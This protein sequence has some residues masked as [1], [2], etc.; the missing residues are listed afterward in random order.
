MFKHILLIASLFI[1]FSIYAQN[2]AVSYQINNLLQ[3]APTYYGERGSKKELHLV[4]K[5]NP[6]NIKAFLGLHA[7]I[8]KYQYDDIM[9]IRI[10]QNTLGD[11]VSLKGLIKAEIHNTPM[12]VMDAT[13]IQL[14]S[15]DTVHA[16]GGSL[17]QAYTGNGV[18]VGI[19]DSG[20]DPTHPDFKNDDG[21]TR[22]LAFWDQNDFSGNLAPYGYGKEYTGVDIDAGLMV[23]Y[24]DTTYNGHGTAVTG[25]AAGGGKVRAD[26]KGMAPEA[27]IVVVGNRPSDLDYTNRMPY[28]LKLVDGI[29]YIF[30]VAE[31]A[32]KPAVI[33]ISLGGIEGSHDAQDLPTQLIERMLDAKNGRALVVSA[34][35]AGSV[36]HHV[37]YKMNRD[38]AFTWYRSMHANTGVCSRDSGAYMSF[39]GDEKDIDNLLINISAENLPCCNGAA[40]ET[41]YRVVKQTVGQ[42]VTY[43]LNNGSTQIGVVTTFLEKIGTTYGY[44]VEIKS[45]EMNRFWR[46]SFT[47]TGKVDGW[48]GPLNRRSCNSDFIYNSLALGGSAS[49][50]RKLGRYVKP[51]LQQNIG[52]AYA[53]SQKVITVGAYSANT[54]MYDI[55]SIR[56]NFPVVQKDRIAFSSIGPTR[57]GVTKPDLTGPGSRVITAQASQELSSMAIS[58]RSSLYLGGKHSVIDGTSFSSPAVAGIVALYLEKN[59]D[60]GYAEIKRALL[61]TTDQ[62]VQ[63]GAEMPNNE[64][65]YGRV[66]AYQMLLYQD[67]VGINELKKLDALVYPNPSSGKFKI[68]LSRLDFDQD[69]ELTIVDLKGQTILESAFKSHEFEFS[70]DLTG[71]YILQL[72]DKEENAYFYKLIVQ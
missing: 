49:E 11:L 9:A 60:A 10:P 40:D 26:V 25:M 55:D 31:A 66:N 37:Q 35:N 53:C 69:Y 32:G 56:R 45:Q 8:L 51:D 46:I 50:T 39:Y 27:D 19:I 22:I 33:N 48:S 29:N 42:K 52:N 58:S 61:N 47:G 20:I 67:P 7:G 18:V 30:K 17:Q 4:V 63:T 21:T 6:K 59:P 12:E 23:N 54:H 62:D 1:T 14:T 71:V 64:N 38:T 70:I 28:M 36:R 57:T 2:A 41:G 13:A 15:V 44:F 65:G 16:G 24:L 43:T 68:E 72:T 3:N 5:G 34:G